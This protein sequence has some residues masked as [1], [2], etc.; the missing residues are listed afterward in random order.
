MS[1]RGNSRLK[2]VGAVVAVGALAA[3]GTGIVGRRQD[4]HKLATWTAEQAVPAVATIKPS[5]IKSGGVLTLPAALQALNSAP[6]YARTQGY[7]QRWL[8]DIGDNVKAGQTLALLDAPEI[9]QQLAAAKADLQTALANQ[10]LADSTAKR[11]SGML[12]KDAVSKQETD[13][14]LGDLAAKTAVTNAAKA[15]VLRLEALAGFKLLVAP[16]DG[17][18]TSRSVQIGALVNAGNAAAQPLFTVA[19]VSRIRAYVRV[20]QQ[21]SAGLKE[22]MAVKM[23]LPEYPGRAFTA[24]LTRTAQAIDPASGTL[25]VELQI[26]NDDR[27]LKPGAYA[28]ADFPLQ[29]ESKTVT[30][31]PSALLFGEHGMQVA[32]LGADGKAELRPVTLGHDQGKVIEVTAGLGADET[33]IDNPPESL[34]T[35]DAVRLANTTE[36]V[37]D[38]AK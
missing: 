15:Q 25:L 28:Q 26:A 33:V 30:L 12:A 17:V 2:L 1:D 3:V 16:F 19:D 24:K 21:S 32:V 23:S 37:A 5:P 7:V 8:V 35:G 10:N 22:G 13:E 31:P 36:K 27:A 6:I 29:G 11:W 14:K 38:A 20:P 4:E 9:D 34:R 18:V